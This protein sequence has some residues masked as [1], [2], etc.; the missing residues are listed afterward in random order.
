MALFWV[1]LG[2]AEETE[3]RFTVNLGPTPNMS[4]GLYNTAKFGSLS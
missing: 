3:V 1:D 2:Q 4:K